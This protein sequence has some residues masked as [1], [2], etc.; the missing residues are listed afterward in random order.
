MIKKTVVWLDTIAFISICAMVLCLPFRGNGLKIF[1]FV[2]LGMLIVRKIFE[3]K[4]GVNPLF[5][6]NFLDKPML[7]FLVAMFLSTVLSENF[8]ESQ[9]V[10]FGR[11]LLYAGIF[12]LVK[13]TVNS[14]KKIYLF[15]STVVFVSFFIGVDALWQYFKGVDWLYGY[16]KGNPG[17]GKLIALSGPFVRY[18]SFSGYLELILPLIVFVSFFRKRWYLSI[19]CYLTLAMLLFSWVY[20]FQRT[21]WLSVSMSLFIVS[22]WFSRKYTVVFVIFILVI[23]FFVPVQVC[24]RALTTFH[25]EGDSGRFKMWR[26]GIELYK[27][28]PLVGRGFETYSKNTTTI[29][30]HLHNTYL[31]LLLDTGLT[32]LLSFLWL[33]FLFLRK[34]FF[35]LSRI[36]NQQQKI[37]FGA[38]IS[39]VL[40]FCIAGLFSTNIIVG[41]GYSIVFWVIF[42][43]TAVLPSLFDQYE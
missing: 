23:S 39:A 42:S 6:A 3:H 35:A 28:K 27:N 21:T 20:V 2:G 13:E 1:L 22:F 31:E 8:Y 34:T 16:S 33:L 12:F 14:R 38:F 26:Q 11:I 29:D 19:I 43:I 40:S 17:V 18:N 15:L 37:I 24:Q 5:K 4:L 25:A 7:L 36:V 9:K 32:G 41:L 30:L 10:F